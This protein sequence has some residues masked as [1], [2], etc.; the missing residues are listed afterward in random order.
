M[1][2]TLTKTAAIFSIVLYSL[3]TLAYAFIVFVGLIVS[4][5]S[6]HADL[7]IG[8]SVF[9]LMGNTL[10]FISI[11]L[12]V[13]SILQIVLSAKILKVVS[14]SKQA[15]AKKFGIIITSIVISALFA[16]FMAIGLI[17]NGINF[18]S[19]VEVA[20]LVMAIIF[21]I[22]DMSKNKNFVETESP[23]YPQPNENYQ[24]TQS[25]TYSDCSVE[26]GK[27]YNQT[28]FQSLNS[29]LESK[30]KRLASLKDQGMISQEE[31]E[32]LRQS[33]IEK[34]LRN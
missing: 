24:Q 4:D 34:E 5:L 1:Q 10:L 20:I 25:P 6:A 8:A 14:A 31:F 17:A 29:E 32:K 16:I 9:S 18:I 13:I 21:Y 2:R 11:P 27:N 30:L 26:I 22:V 33:A 23:V 3:M 28:Q 12:L 15:F 19:L 7:A